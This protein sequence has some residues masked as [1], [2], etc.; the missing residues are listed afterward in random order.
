L[1]SAATLFATLPPFD[2]K[3]PASFAHDNKSFL[4]VA[5]SKLSKIGYRHQWK[6]R[7]HNLISNAEASLR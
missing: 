4:L 1:D 5:G 7:I 6:K 2:K 3:D